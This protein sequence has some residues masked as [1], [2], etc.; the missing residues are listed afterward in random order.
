MST[1]TPIIEF[2]VDCPTVPEGEN[3]ADVFTAAWITEAQAAGIAAADVT[4]NADSLAA[5]L[6]DDVWGADADDETGINRYNLWADTDRVGAVEV[7]G[8]TLVL[9]VDEHRDVIRAEYL[10]EIIDDAGEI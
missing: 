6:H 5:N 10:Q 3:L 4:V 7:E 1:I 2:A 8:E 9:V